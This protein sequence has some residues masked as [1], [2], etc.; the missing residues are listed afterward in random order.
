MLVDGIVAELEPLP[1]VKGFAF[2][3][4]S[5]ATPPASKRAVL[6]VELG[7]IVR[8]VNIPFTSASLPLNESIRSATFALP[9]MIRIP[10]FIFRALPQRACPSLGSDLWISA[11]SLK[12]MSAS[13]KLRAGSFGLDALPFPLL[14]L[15]P[16]VRDPAFRGVFE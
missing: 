4:N 12:G 7:K 8:S 9:A 6:H 2:P 1:R 5:A 11:T 10:A 13:S 15:E 16:G 14:D 3:K